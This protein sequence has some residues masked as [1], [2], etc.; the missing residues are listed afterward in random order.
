MPFKPGRCDDK[1]NKR[2]PA[3]GRLPDASQG[4]DHVR[5]V[6]TR[7][8]FNDQETV[9]L[10]GAHTLGR[11]HVV[12]SGYDGPWTRNPLRFD[13]QYFRNLLTLQWKVKEWDGPKQFVDVLTGELVRVLRAL[14][15][16]C[17][18]RLHTRAHRGR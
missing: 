9:A 15:L 17:R 18:P 10:C 12:R 2:C 1:D 16:V 13:N 7:M 8:G 6:F 14:L 3:N 11:C 5:A 4:A